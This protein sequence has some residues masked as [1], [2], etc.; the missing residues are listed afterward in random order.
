MNPW[1]NR[2]VG[3]AEVNPATLKVNP[4]NWRVHPKVQRDTLED[5]LESIGWIQKPVVNKKTG[6]LIDGHLRVAAALERGE[7]SIP[8]SYVELTPTEERAALASLDPLAAM[9]VMDADKLTELLTGLKVGGDSLNALFDELREQA[10]GATLQTSSRVG[11][12]MG[13]DAKKPPMIKAV[14]AVSNAVT[15]ERALAATGSHNRGDALLI[16]CGA[17]LHAAN[18]KGQ[19]DAGAKDFAAAQP[20]EKDFLARGAGDARGQGPGLE[21]GVQPDTAGRRV[22]AGRGK[23]GTAGRPAA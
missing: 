3:E 14:I 4:L 23:G 9:A 11:V 12:N 20:S 22:R 6:H 7:A 8:V 13:E 5:S 2:I 19:H 15:I 10:T 16:I 1:R 21:K 17:Y 18:E